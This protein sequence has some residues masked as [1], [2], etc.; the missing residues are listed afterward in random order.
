MPGRGPEIELGFEIFEVQGKVENV[1]VG[2]PGCRCGRVGPSVPRTECR[3]CGKARG[4]EHA[5]TAKHGGLLPVHIRRHEALQFGGSWREHDE[6]VP[7][8]SELQIPR[9]QGRSQDEAHA[10]VND[11]R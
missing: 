8:P 5:T 11:R 10:G 9:R 2:D 1:G 7:L 4:R 6:K 3:E